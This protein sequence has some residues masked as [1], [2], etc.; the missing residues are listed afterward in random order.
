MRQGSKAKATKKTV[1]LP[2]SQFL[3]AL[4]TANLD[5]ACIGTGLK[6]IKGE[7]RNAIKPKATRRLTGSIDLDAAL[8]TALPHDSRWDY[9][10][11]LLLADNKTEVAIWIE[12]HP[13][14]T[15]EVDRILLKLDWLKARLKQ[16]AALGK[17]TAK[18]EEN[19]V[20]PF[21]WL[22]TD[23]G[24]H[25]HAHMPQARRLAARG[26]PLPTSILRLP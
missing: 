7:H 11:G 15:G 4:S 10:V 25:I 18:S 26:I 20:Q 17:L 6:A 22:P 9:G 3:K 14:T 21:H 2:T 16:Y 12:V 8:S 1:A 13:A 24:V 5:A 19:N 23:S